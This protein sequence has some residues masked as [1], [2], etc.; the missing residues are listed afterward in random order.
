MPAAAGRGTSSIHHARGQF[1]DH[2]TSQVSP[3][4]TKTSPKSHCST[5]RETKADS[6]DRVI[7]VSPLRWHR[8]PP[9]LTSRPFFF[10]VRPVRTQGYEARLKKLL[11][12]LV[13]PSQ[14]T[15]FYFSWTADVSFR[16][17]NSAAKG[18]RSVGALTLLSASTSC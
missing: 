7:F 3:W 5:A 10:N 1:C 13:Q 14:H 8:V 15:S 17:P 18:N 6:V 4:R 12:L 11:L 9:R 2:D 16:F